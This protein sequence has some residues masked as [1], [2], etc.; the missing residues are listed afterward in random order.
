[1]AYTAMHGVDSSTSG[2]KYELLEKLE[3]WKRGAAIAKGRE[4]TTL[5]SY[6]EKIPYSL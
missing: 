5:P 6:I 3:S 4:R 2:G 1:M